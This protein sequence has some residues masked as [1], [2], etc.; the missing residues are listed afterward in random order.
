MADTLA[1]L[2][3]YCQAQGWLD[4]STAG[5][6]ALTD[7]INDSLQSLAS[8]Y[9]WPWYRRA[10][11]FNLTAPYST[12]TVT[13]TG[14]STAVAGTGTA[15]FAAGMADQEFYTSED[16]GRVY[17]ISTVGASAE[18]L[19]L[20]S[21]YLGDSATLAS[22]EIRYV[23]YALPSD[24]D[25]ASVFRTQDGRDLDSS[26]TLEEWNAARM[27]HRGTVDMP[28]HLC[29]QTTNNAGFYVHPAPTTAKQ[30]RYVYY[31]K[32]ATITSSVNSDWPT[33]YRYL[34][35][36]VL[37]MRMN[38]DN[39][40]VG[41]LVASSRELQQQIDRAISRSRPTQAPLVIRGAGR[42]GMSPSEYASRFNIVNT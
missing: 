29:V 21:A 18:T 22:Y 41:M 1:T 4:K 40:D 9:S 38:T 32:P 23:K 33:T 14:A 30:V 34:L 15:N 8:L 12:G 27:E 2:Q 35:H 26:M 19:T 36:A 24:F 3:T 5:L 39:A 20:A 13:L 6:V 28:T 7:F 10:A 17:Q 37:R 31:A 16:T 42:G 11:A 25:R